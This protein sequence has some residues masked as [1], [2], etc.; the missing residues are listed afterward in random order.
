MGHTIVLEVPDEIYDPL[1]KTAQAENRKIEDIA[2]EL[3][4]A[5]ATRQAT[6]LNPISRRKLSMEEFRHSTEAIR[7]RMPPQK[8]DSTDLIRQDRESR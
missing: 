6:A 4:T 1:A 7:N 2:I 3:L 5:A 8:S